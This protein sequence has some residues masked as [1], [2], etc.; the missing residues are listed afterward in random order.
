MAEGYLKDHASLIEH[1]SER[2]WRALRLHGHMRSGATEEWQHC[3]CKPYSS[4]PATGMR[5]EYIAGQRLN[6]VE[7]AQV[8]PAE[9]DSSSR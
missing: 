2:G 6:D 1:I 4:L 5:A 8:V 7:R 9:R 3:Y